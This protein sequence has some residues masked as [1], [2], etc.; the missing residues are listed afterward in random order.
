[1]DDAE[2][3]VLDLIFG[4]WLSQILYAGVQL[5]VFEAL[6]R[7]PASAGQIASALQV[8][9]RLLYRLMRALG[10]LALLHEDPDQRFILTPM[11]EVLCRD[12][13]QSLRGL[14]LLEAGPEHAAA[15]THLSELITAG[16]QDTF[17]REVG[18]SVYTYAEHDSSYDAILDEGLRTYARLDH[19]LVVEALAAYDFSCITHLFDVGGGHGLTLGSLLVQHPHLRGTVLERPRVL[20]QPDAFWAAKLGVGD[21]CTYV[22]GDMFHAVPPADAYLLKRILHNWNDAECGQIL[23]TIHRAAPSQGRVFIIEHIVPG[24]DTPHFAKLCDLQMLVLLTGRERTLE[25][26]T[27]LLAGA[28]RTYRQTWCPAS[29]R[30]GAVEAVKA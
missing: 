23:S 12:H 24:P 25:E 5:G 4:S 29:K 27:G 8:E 28:G 13:P 21:R 7:G 20:A 3:K 30:L 26:Y 16:Q 17:G 11:G 1:M 19:P 15:W 10:A 9:A 6:G 18:E 2:A 14:T 22:S